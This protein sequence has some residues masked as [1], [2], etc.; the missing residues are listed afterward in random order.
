VLALLADDGET[1][2]GKA[3]GAGAAGG[4]TPDAHAVRGAAGGALS[5][6]TIAFVGP[7]PLSLREY[8]ARLR[9][10]LGL[11]HRQPVIAL[12]TALFRAGAAV[13][14]KLPGSFLDLATADMLL[15]GNAAPA[16]AFTRVLG[17]P[18]R[19]PAHF[20]EPAQADPLRREAL[21]GLWL[22]V[23]RVTLAALWIWTAAVSFGLYPVQGS[24]ELLAQVGLSGA[25]A[26]LALYGAA[27]LDLAMGLL[28]LW[29]PPR[30]RGAVWACQLLLIAGYTLLITL[31][32][33]AYWLH[34]Y[35]PISKNLP[36]MAGIA[37]LWALEP[38][39]ARRGR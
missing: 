9:A 10:G 34:P 11:T 32:L 1:A 39:L 28:T 3:A 13:A 18:P 19:A 23:L 15:R 30:W 35:G 14:A 31:F 5:A 4:E 26:T 8:L 37:L 24:Y 36:I 6:Q 7:E 29:A 20:I 16:A 2:A 22:P 27:A 21:L 17:R 33:P 12:P 25:I 38:P